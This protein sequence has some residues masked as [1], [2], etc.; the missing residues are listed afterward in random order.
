VLSYGADVLWVRN[1][2]RTCLAM[3]LNRLGGNM[4]ARLQHILCI[5]D[6][7]DI[8]EV[9]Q[10]SLELVGGFKVT[11]LCSGRDA[12]DKAAAIA[13][14]LILLDVMMP[15]LDGPSTLQAL[16]RQTGLRD[17]PIVFM[18]ARVQPAE[19]QQYLD[20]GAAG[21]TAKPFDAMTLPGQITE[22]W[23]RFHAS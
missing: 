4:G 7:S 16:R 23:E 5:D 1:G 6:E 10:L 8:L 11:C 2:Q 15:Q 20:L 19:V 17:V 9:A 18:T 3:G 21:V 13:P 14:D 22:M 12:I